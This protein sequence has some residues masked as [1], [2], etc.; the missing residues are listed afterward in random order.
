M[1]RF[2][3]GIAIILAGIGVGFL[4]LRVFEATAT[5]V[6][7][8]VSQPVSP[9]QGIRGPVLCVY[10]PPRGGDSLYA[11]TREGLYRSSDGGKGWRRIFTRRLLEGL[12]TVALGPGDPPVLYVATERGIFSSRDDGKQWRRLLSLKGPVSCLVIDP[13]APGTVLV[14]TEQGIWR[15]S[16]RGSSWNPVGQTGAMGAVLA[17]AFHPVNPHLC[18]ALTRAGLFRSDDRA[19]TWNRVWV[20]RRDQEGPSSEEAEEPEEAPSLESG[21]LAIASGTGILYLGAGRGVVKSPDGGATWQGLPTI[22]A[23][24]PRVGQILL[25]S[26]SP[27]SLY[28]ATEDGLFHY[29]ESQAAWSSIREGLPAGRIYSAGLD[30]TGDHLWVGTEKGLFR[31]PAVAPAKV[32][33]EG[34]QPALGGVALGLLHEPSIREVQEAAIRYG[35]VMPQKIRAWRA[36]AAW[37]NFFPKF[38]VNLNQDTDKTIASATSGGKTNFA[39]GP[40][41]QSL[42]LGFGF[43]WDLAN[44]VWNPDQTSIDVRSRLMVQLRQ[45]LLEG[46]TRLYFE[47]RRLLAEFQGNPSEDP[48]LKTERSLRIEEL[49]A[50]ID[51]LTGGWFSNSGT[52][53]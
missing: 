20:S 7:P 32:I 12:R 29:S 43:T 42:S 30:S 44:L 25:D 1:K 31:V 40:E 21:G 15:G 24:T 47:R 27:G 45:D 37:R 5:S 49:T 6:L 11:A 3:S 41:D 36:G 17:L 26:R 16:D 48:V 33:L 38:S 39:I 23:G 14:G 19:E 10:S 28:A 51:A 18:Y 53:P 46:V 4:C 50:Q 13:A 2:R 22:G 34:E 9:V 52:S 35:E 8:L